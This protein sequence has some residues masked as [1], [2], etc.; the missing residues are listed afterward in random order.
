LPRLV[1]K[2]IPCYGYLAR[3]PHAA[4]QTNLDRFANP[5]RRAFTAAYLARAERRHIRRVR[6]LRNA[7]NICALDAAW[8]TVQGIPSR[9]ISNTWSD[10]YATNWRDMRIAAEKR[11]TGLHILGNIGGLNAT[12]NRFGIEYLGG[13]VVPFLREKLEGEWTINICGRF[14]LPQSLKDI[15]SDPHVALRGFVPDIDEEVAGNSI[16]LLLNNAGPYTG[17]YTRVIYAFSS[18]SCLIAHRRLADSMPE[19]VHNENCLLGETP[20]EIAGLIQQAARDV[21][22]R[23]RLGYAARATYERDYAPRHVAK[24]LMGMISE[25]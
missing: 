2:G 24:K 18:G 7:A 4:G 22:L 6:L 13:K 19:L 17:G 15:L 10:A 8:Y 1:A 23:E 5:L 20:Q 25:S 21:T 16:F 14:E 11:R 12:G 9:Y 3:P